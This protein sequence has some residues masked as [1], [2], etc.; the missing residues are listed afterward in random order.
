MGFYED[1][2]VSKSKINYRKIKNILK[3]TRAQYRHPEIH[4]ELRKIPIKNTAEHQASRPTFE[5]T[6]PERILQP[7]CHTNLH[8][9]QMTGL[10]CKASHLNL[11]VRAFNKSVYET[12]PK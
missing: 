4:L 12:Q 1:L 6:S 7:Y 8:V 3:W 2:P 11:N 10:W 9:N 5:P